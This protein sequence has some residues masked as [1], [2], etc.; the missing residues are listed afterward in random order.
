MHFRIIHFDYWCS[1]HDASGYNVL[2][3]ITEWCLVTHGLAL[4]QSGF[5]F[6]APLN[7][8]L[9][10]I[11]VAHPWFKGSTVV[12]FNLRGFPTRTYSV[13]GALH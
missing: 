10:V 8:S 5:K 3:V 6:C 4:W 12:Q 2:V 11:K 9:S 1:S 7:F 13:F